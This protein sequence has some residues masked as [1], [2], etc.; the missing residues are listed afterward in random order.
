MSTLVVGIGHKCRNGKDSFAKFL[1]ACDPIN[2]TIYS[3]ADALKAYC[4]V[5]GWMKEKDG[6][7]LQQVGTELFRERI[8]K[9]TWVNCLRWQI[10]EENPKIAIIPDM[11]F[12]NEVEYVKE[13]GGITVNIVRM[14]PDGSNWI[15]STRPADHISEITLDNYKYDYVFKAHDGNVESLKNDAELFYSNTL[16]PMVEQMIRGQIW[17]R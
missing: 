5:Q 4:R 15:D 2:S 6:A 7:L 16:K 9:N 3:F 12:L 17:T 10:I 8:N 14:K 13:G 11:R 1:H